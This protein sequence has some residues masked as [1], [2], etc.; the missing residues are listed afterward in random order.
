MRTP[1]I[2]LLWQIWWQHRGS[3]AAI[4]G[5]TVAGRVVDTDRG[6]GDAS[7]ALILLALLAFLLLFGVFGYTESTDGR[8]FGRFPER[9]F[10][11]P[12]TTLRLVAI[13]MLA[14]M[15]AVE[16]LYLLWIEPLFGHG[17]ADAWFVGV[18][19]AAL[20][21]FYLWALWTLQRAG[22]L[23]LV[24]LGLLATGVFVI[25]ILPSFP[26]T[27]AP[28]WRSEAALAG[29][30]AL[31]AVAAFLVAWRHV[32]DLRSGGGGRDR[33]DSLWGAMADAIPARRTPFASAA[34]AQFWYEWRSSGIVL[35][36]LVGG[37]VLVILPMSWA[38][39]HDAAATFRLLMAT[40]ATPI[41]LAVPVGAAFSKPR[42]W[43]DD[44]TI[45]SFVA[46]RPLSADDLVA[47]K[48]RVAAASTA[49][50]W[51]VVLGFMA[52]WLPLW[53]DLDAVRAVTMPLRAAH[54]T[55]PAAAGAS[56]LVL[57]ALVV[58]TWRFLVNRL[59]VGLS[60]MRPLFV[61]SFVSV[62]VIGFTGLALDASGLP[63]WVLDEPARAELIIWFMLAAVVAKFGVAVFAWRHVAS[64]YVRTYALVWLAATA[65]LMGLGL[66]SWRMVRSIA[67]LDGDRVVTAIVLLAL[68]AVPLAR[69][70][71]APLTLAKNRH[72]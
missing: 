46:V 44:L 24:V 6:A 67:W 56:V 65:I 15:G 40:L 69:V 17:I 18:L 20:F 62:I 54:G 10:I 14:G 37:V 11:L 13:P 68:L 59:S 21:V 60:G 72:R 31:L 45:P 66:V 28:A 32:A 34:A 55:R 50:A 70:G 29:F 43:S 33:A 51:A 38:A 12:V 35:P 1:T 48:L 49:L 27:P 42:F 19:L 26:P 47:T 23:R 71:L 4:A 3:I 5:L 53:A 2:T 61:G 39:R 25:A 7:P 57:G 63:E 8:A 58:L 9:L 52:V 36:A 64:G 16:L 22:S 41:V 30:V